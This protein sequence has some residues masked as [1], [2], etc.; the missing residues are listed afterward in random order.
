[1]LRQLDRA[2]IVL[3]ATGG[4]APLVANALAAAQPL[5]VINPRRIREFAKA[6]GKLAK[7]DRLD[8]AIIAHFAAVRPPPRPVTAAEAVALSE[9]VTRRLQLILTMVAGRNRARLVRKLLVIRNAMLRD[10]T[11][12]TIACLRSRES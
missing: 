10:K 4:Y 3:E 2:L 8:A 1:V 5:A 11:R 9:P 12:W 7:T 6:V